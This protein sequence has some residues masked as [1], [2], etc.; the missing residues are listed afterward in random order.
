MATY[1][2][3]KI[4]SPKSLTDALKKLKPVKSFDASKH[5][6][7]VNWVEEPLEYQKRLRDEW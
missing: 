4:N 7:K 1:K 6:G 5:L 3:K 2:V